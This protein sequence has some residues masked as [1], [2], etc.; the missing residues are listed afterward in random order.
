MQSIDQLPL[1]QFYYNKESHR[2]A[3][4]Q[5]TS[6]LFAVLVYFLRNYLGLHQTRTYLVVC[7]VGAYFEPSPDGVF[8]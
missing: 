6:I 4:S 1:S 2:I 7:W 3:I 5:G 8:E